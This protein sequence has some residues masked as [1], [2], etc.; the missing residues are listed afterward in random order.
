[1][2]DPTLEYARR[3]GILTAEIEQL[4][5]S[6]LNAISSL[7][8]L[9]LKQAA[10]GGSIVAMCKL[11]EQYLRGR[12]DHLTGEV[13]IAWA[14]RA[15]QEDFAPAQALLGHYLERGIGAPRD[16]TEA[17]RLFE[18]AAEQGYGPAA[19]HLAIQISEGVLGRP[20]DMQRATQ[21]AALAAGTGDAIAAML[22]AE[23]YEVGSGLDRDPTSAL[24]WYETAAE[25]G[26]SLAAT[27]LAMAYS[28]GDAK[29][30]VDRDA[31]KAQKFLA[32]SE[33]GDI[34]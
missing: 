13:G 1:M 18:S 31:A 12:Q 25:L 14:R 23:W 22:L 8:F 16:Q 29:L 21:L 32:L 3:V 27:R 5:T 15:A 11:S 17:Y 6:S 20:P 24:R 10:E 34:P 26:N 7:Q 9:R 33:K 28:F 19:I 4:C 2:I 30:M